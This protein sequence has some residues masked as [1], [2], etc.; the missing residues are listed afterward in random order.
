MIH[1]QPGENAVR[2]LALESELAETKQT[3]T[4]LEEDNRLLEEKVMEQ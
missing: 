1:I 2:I 4:I 3:N